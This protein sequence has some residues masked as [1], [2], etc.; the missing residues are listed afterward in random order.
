MKTCL[1]VI[2]PCYVELSLVLKYIPDVNE[3]SVI[4][5]DPSTTLASGGRDTQSKR[6]VKNSTDNLADGVV[7]LC[8]AVQLCILP[9]QPR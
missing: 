1:C 5:L 3:D 7:G 9:K 2:E 8:S 6:Q 4:N